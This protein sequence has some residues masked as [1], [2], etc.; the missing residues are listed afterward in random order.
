MGK[1]LKHKNNWIQRVNRMQRDR[2]P[3]LLKKSTN[4]WEEESEDD[5]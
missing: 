4:R 2:I 1:V 5:Q 3:K